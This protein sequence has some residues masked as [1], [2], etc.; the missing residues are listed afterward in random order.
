MSQ[1]EGWMPLFVTRYL[2]DTEQLNTAQHGAYLLLLMHYW[3]HGPLDDDDNA[4]AAIAR[5]DCRAWRA[6]AATIRK[7]F[8]PHDGRLFQKRME[9]ER[10]R[11]TD[12]SSKRRAA[13]FAS[14]RTPP[15]TGGGIRA[16]VGLSNGAANAHANAP[17]VSANGGANAVAIAVSEPANASANA[18]SK[19]ANAPTLA[20]A[21][22]PVHCTQEERISLLLFKKEEAAG[23]R[24]T[25]APEL[26]SVADV[27]AARAAAAAEIAALPGGF[28][29]AFQ[30]A[31]KA[32]RH[33][34]FASG[35]YQ[36]VKP[37]VY[38][39]AAKESLRQRPGAKLLNQELLDAMPHRQRAKAMA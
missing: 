12:I 19:G 13:A 36:P 38:Q 17:E 7:F 3:R 16:E 28:G 20:G 29:S 15:T 5:L 39:E 9:I 1:S 11:A 14:H 27:M 32:V 21:N 25:E 6:N 18:V 8:R 26:P 10:A 31:G 37:A 34:E 4:L 30:Q 35:A 24:E 2:N 33:V 22:A 23:A